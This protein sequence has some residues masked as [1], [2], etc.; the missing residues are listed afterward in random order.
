MH[1]VKTKY[2][3]ALFVM[4][5]LITTNMVI[6][7]YLFIQQADDANVINIA[8][9][10]RMLSQRIALLSDSVGS[11]QYTQFK[12]SIERFEQNHDFL[13]QDDGRDYKFLTP[14]LMQLYFSAPVELDKQ[15]QAF[16]QLAK[17]QIQTPSSESKRLLMA[18]SQQILPRLNDAVTLF[19]QMSED[20]TQR[21]REVEAVLWLLGLL[22]LFIELRFVFNPMHQR[23]HSTL[24]QITQ[25]KQEAEDALQSKSRFLA[26][27]SHELR[28][29]LQA[30]QG[31]LHLF[32]ENKSQNYLQETERSIQQLGH[33]IASVEDFNKLKNQEIVIESQRTHL[34]EI[35][36]SACLPYRL[37]AHEKSLNFNLALSNDLDVCCHCDQTRVAWLIGEL[38]ENAIK[39]T[40]RGSVQI[41]ADLLVL[42]SD[43]FLE[44]LVEDSGP[45]F[46]YETW[47]ESHQNE[48]F[49]GIQL[50]LQRCKLLASAMGGSL[51]F[52]PIEP[53]GTRAYLSLP[54]KFEHN[55]QL[56]SCTSV[57]GAKL[58]LVEDNTLNAK[59]IEKMLQSIVRSIDHAEHGKRALELFSDND[60]DLIIMDLNMPVMNGF[61][62]IAAIR[63]TDH[64]IPIIVVTANTSEEDI[65]KA[66]KMGATAHLFKPLQ[67]DAL[68]QK[69]LMLLNPVAQSA[70]S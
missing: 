10:Q 40:E 28:T 21:L 67:P 50:G 41:F 62:A 37:K 15:V 14:E 65:L 46:D 59:V 3:M 43:T 70:T 4:A 63:E 12:N 27:V 1:N 29:P 23:I 39:F 16:I 19:E 6:M 45:G 47:L 22:V 13:L 53:V 64:T 24:K 69:T 8:G 68:Q 61:E 44:I 32:R 7:Q 20:K 48:H 33:L 51:S 25:A 31:Y 60:Y 55:H 17:V 34:Q 49:Q 11:E 58:L 36:K 5:S 30:A 26:R 18:T 56:E 52:H 57:L 54:L 9:M 66:Y 38:I 42:E 35:V 2:R